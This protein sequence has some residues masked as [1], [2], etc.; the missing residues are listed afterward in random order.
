MES[1]KTFG[2]AA[3]IGLALAAPALGQ[4]VV[5]GD[6]IKLNGTAYRIWGMDAAETKQRCLDGW[7]TGQEASKAMLE[8]V[9]GRKMRC[10]PRV[11]DRYGR[12]VGLCRAD[13][14]DVGA[15]MVSTGM[16]WAFT[17]YTS[18]YVDQE[19]N[20]IGSLRGVH[21]HDCEKPWDR[22]ARSKADRHRTSTTVGL[23][24]TPAEVDS[25]K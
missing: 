23:A 11:T 12:T 17:R 24:K 2:L 22:R 9:M 13:G 14:Q 25:S 8:F 1:G 3:L 18:D 10:E 16:A 21:A 4:T 7:T 20:A 15:A 5:D 19:K 6:T